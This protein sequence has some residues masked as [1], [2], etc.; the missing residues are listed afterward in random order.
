MTD[1]NSSAITE[2]ENSAVAMQELPMQNSGK[3]SVNE[4][5]MDEERSS[6]RKF[7]NII[8]FATLYNWIFNRVRLSTIIMLSSLMP[9][10]AAMFW[11]SQVI[12]ERAVKFNLVNDFSELSVLLDDTV[13]LRL[14]LF[15][16]REAVLSYY[17]D[18][19]LIEVQKVMQIRAQ[20]QAKYETLL[21][22]F[23]R[24]ATKGLV[25][26]DFEGTLLKTLQT[27]EWHLESLGAYGDVTD[28][29]ATG[30]FIEFYT[31]YNELLLDTIDVFFAFYKFSQ[32]EEIR[33]EL[34]VLINFMGF[35][36]TSHREHVF[37]LAQDSEDIYEDEFI[38]EVNDIIRRKEIARD[39][40]HSLIDFDKVTIVDELLL[41]PLKGHSSSVLVQGLLYSSDFKLKDI[42]KW[43]EA[44]NDRLSLIDSFYQ[45]HVGDNT[46]NIKDKLYQSTQFSRNFNAIFVGIVLLSVVSSI[47]RTTRYL[48]NAFHR[49]SSVTGELAR[50]NINVH[51]PAPNNNEVG[52]MFSALAILKENAVER[53][54]LSEEQQNNAQRRQKRAESMEELIAS[55]DDTVGLVLKT[56]DDAS[57]KLQ[58]TANI[59]N[60]SVAS[61]SET[62]N[63]AAEKSLATSEDVKNMVESA[64]NLS[65]SVNQVA[66]QFKLS[67][68]ITHRSA[69]RAEKVDEVAT[70]LSDATQQISDVLGIIKDIASQI[71][72][73]ALNATIEAARAGEAGKGFAVV[74][75]EVKNLATQTS[76]STD[77][78]DV[79]IDD[80]QTITTEAL[81]ILHG[82]KDA[83]V[84][85]QSHSTDIASSSEQQAQTTVQISD[86]MRITA[87]SVESI[88]TDINRVQENAKSASNA[89]QDVNS[90]VTAL[91]EQSATLSH[92]V[93]NFLTDI[94]KA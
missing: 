17:L 39:T 34:L 18:P 91:S 54:R 26:G 74:A 82:L 58:N 22:N 12:Y 62:A 66:K 69:E 94:R 79:L 20:S 87:S 38:A 65:I 70:S 42:A 55:F 1:N 37:I 7:F 24:L 35:Y 43:H 85:V 83:I 48:I 84:E 46:K 27:F 88:G 36:E 2:Q 76:E 93:N 25:A 19:E 28:D 44:S 8:F 63:V 30:D 4:A 52:E 16:E 78:I 68:D 51:V 15:K 53:E 75:G 40:Y 59:M 13:A 21:E 64:A 57:Q 5:N 61:T 31:V 45:Q 9:L 41:S 23:Q 90:A 49:V 6:L 77:K 3:A 32:I 89:A 81:E 80:V 56:I 33:H 60:E 50:G 92:A 86:N 11:G 71:N 72:L 67:A 73:L 14:S 47:V 10:V 29:T